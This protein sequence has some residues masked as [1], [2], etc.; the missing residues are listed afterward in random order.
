MSC[1][2]LCEIIRQRAAPE[3]AARELASWVAGRNRQQASGRR[4]GVGGSDLRWAGRPLDE[5]ENCATR[6][7]GLLRTRVIGAQRA[8]GGWSPNGSGKNCAAL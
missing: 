1:R 8:A 7:S 5:P 3:G 2:T 4:R 6:Q